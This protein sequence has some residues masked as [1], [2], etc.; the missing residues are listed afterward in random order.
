M[1]VLINVVVRILLILG[2]SLIIIIFVFIPSINSTEIL[3]H[4]VDGKLTLSNCSF[5][6]NPKLSIL[7]VLLCKY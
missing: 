7:N 5:V 3:N 6:L 2:I 4:L 1:R